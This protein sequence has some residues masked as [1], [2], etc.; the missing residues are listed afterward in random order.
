MANPACPKAEQDSTGQ[1]P[2]DSYMLSD[3]SMD[4]RPWPAHDYVACWEAP[5]ILASQMLLDTKMV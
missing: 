5:V 2:N 4:P 1:I 3:I